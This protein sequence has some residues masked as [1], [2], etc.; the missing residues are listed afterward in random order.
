MILNYLLHKV[1]IKIY[2][3]IQKQYISGVHMFHTQL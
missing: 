3:Q 2:K 1:Q